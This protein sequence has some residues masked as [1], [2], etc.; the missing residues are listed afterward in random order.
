[1]RN[2]GPKSS[3]EL[4]VISSDGIGVIRRAEPPFD[5][6]EEQ[7]IEWMA[8]VNR[9]PADWFTKENHGLLAQYCRHIISSRRVSQLI[10]A[11]E[12]NEEFSIHA[13]DVLLKMQARESSA[14]MSL[15]TKM[16]LTQQA[17]YT[18]KRAGTKNNDI[19]THGKPWKK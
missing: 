13:Y 2:K 19:P 6:T 11:E 8:I 5:L 7:V 10:K 4:S 17:K 1:M 16:R 3:A 18:A 12:D 15:G 14:L 9:L